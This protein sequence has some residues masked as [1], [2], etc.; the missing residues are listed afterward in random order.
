M[1]AVATHTT[2]RSASFWS[3]LK[4]G[5]H[6]LHCWA[7][8]DSLS[9]A[10]E[11]FMA[12]GLLAGQA[13]IVIGAAPHVHEAEKR[14]RSKWI[15]VDRARWEQRYMPLLA[16]EVLARIMGKDGLPDEARF[17]AVMTDLLE[18]TR[19]KERG[20]RAFGEMV[21]VLWSEGNTAG[22]IMLE[23]L[24]NRFIREHRVALLCAYDRTLFDRRPDALKGIR[25]EHTALLPG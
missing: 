17:L 16:H 3:E 18:R 12:A 14:L 2:L 5:D 15:D 7:H 4:P 24:W 20:A 13:V 11:G 23:N 9:T 8:E 1:K 25:A 19:G 6:L 10:L 22:T 21:N